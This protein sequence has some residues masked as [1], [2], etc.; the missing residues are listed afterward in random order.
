MSIVLDVVP[1]ATAKYIRKNTGKIA[2]AID[3][4]S[5]LLHGEIYQALLSAGVPTS[6]ARN[7]AWAIDA[8]LL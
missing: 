1:P 3:K 4:A 6:I 2:N 7:I 8:F 5:S